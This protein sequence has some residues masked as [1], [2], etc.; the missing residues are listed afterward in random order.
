MLRES[1]DQSEKVGYKDIWKGEDSPC[2][3]TADNLLRRCIRDEMNDWKTNVL[4]SIGL[5][6]LS[7]FL[8]IPFSQSPIQIYCSVL[9]EEKKKLLTGGHFVLLIT[10]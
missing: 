9:F 10:K 2:P 6:K 5:E 8:H 1:Q 4:L 7:K 3:H